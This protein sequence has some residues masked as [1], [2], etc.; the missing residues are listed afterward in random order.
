MREVSEVGGLEGDGQIFTPRAIE[1]I[2]FII[3]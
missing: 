2:L 1:Q 3:T